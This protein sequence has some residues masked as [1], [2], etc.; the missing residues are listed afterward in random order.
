MANKYSPTATQDGIEISDRI[1]SYTCII[2]KLDSGQYDEKPPEWL[3]ILACILEAK[4]AG[5]IAL[6]IEMELI[7]WR[8]LVVTVF[9]GEERKRNGTVEISNNKGGVDLAVMYIGKH[10]GI[11]IDPASERFVLAHHVEGLAIEKYGHEIGSGLALK[12]YQDMVTICPCSGFKLSVTGREGFEIMHDDFIER[13]K[14]DGMPE[15]PV[16][17]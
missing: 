16:A 12:V 11:N 8:W 15:I 7:I 9:V 6:P 1:I 17:H 10:G 2:N 13:L 14:T 3:R 5:W 4:A